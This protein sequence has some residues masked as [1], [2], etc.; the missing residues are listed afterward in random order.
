MLIIFYKTYIHNSYISDNPNLDAKL[1]NFGNSTI[2]YCIFYNTKISCYEPHTCQLI[3]LKNLHVIRDVNAHKEFKICTREDIDTVLSEKESR[4]SLILEDN[5]NNLNDNKT[6][7]IQNE[8]KS[9]SLFIIILG[10]IIVTCIGIFV[11]FMF[12]KKSKNKKSNESYF[13]LDDEKQTKI[14]AEKNRSNIEI[15]NTNTKTSVKNN[16]N[17]YKI[18]QNKTIMANLNE[19]MEEIYQRG[20]YSSFSSFGFSSFSSK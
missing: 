18:N 1:I 3:T 14:I 15:N 9:N 4:N 17:T 8:K 16:N 7:A 6:D 19:M 13:N 2:K 12:I 5:K 11:A 10:C 20:S